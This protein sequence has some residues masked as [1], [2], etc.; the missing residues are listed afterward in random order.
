MFLKALSVKRANQSRSKRVRRDHVCG[1][2]SKLV[3]DSDFDSES[4]FESDSESVVRAV[5]V[6]Y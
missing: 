4:D 3:D 6:R 5:V 2:A 1:H